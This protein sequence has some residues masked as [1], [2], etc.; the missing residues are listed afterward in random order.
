MRCLP[1]SPWGGG[2]V[3]H[4]RLTVAVDLL[5]GAG[6]AVGDETRRVLGTLFADRREP[7]PARR[8][9]E[10]PRTRAHQR[11]SFASSLG[12]GASPVVGPCIAEWGWSRQRVIGLVRRRA[13]LPMM[14][15]EISGCLHAAE[16]SPW[17]HA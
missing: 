11:E 4:L 14:G 10:G 17:P 6:R 7:R 13:G 16:G 2:L 3:S 15:V 8:H 5:A 9:G 1:T 12:V